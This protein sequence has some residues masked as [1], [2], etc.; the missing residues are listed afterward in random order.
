MVLLHPSL[1]LSVLLT[2]CYR[3]FLLLLLVAAVLWKIKQ[4]YDMYRRRQVSIFISW[5][6]RYKDHVLSSGFTFDDSKQCTDSRN[7]ILDLMAM[8]FI[9]KIQTF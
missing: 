4:R 2:V 9:L 1:S 8:L 5:L 7:I 3:C 6:F